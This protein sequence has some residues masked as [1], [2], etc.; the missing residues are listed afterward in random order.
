[1]RV[2]KFGNYEEKDTLYMQFAYYETAMEWPQAASSYSTGTDRW[3]TTSLALV[4]RVRPCILD[5]GG[6]H[7]KC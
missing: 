2:D 1:M 6:S 5:F 3:P 7:R 4:H